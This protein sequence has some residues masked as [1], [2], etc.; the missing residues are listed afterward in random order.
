MADTW[1]GHGAAI[2]GLPDTQKSILSWIDGRSWLIQSRI[3]VAV[4]LFSAKSDRDSDPTPAQPRQKVDP[5]EALGHILAKEGMTWSCC[6]CGQTWTTAAIK[7]VA[8]LGRCPGPKQWEQEPNLNCQTWRKIQGSRLTINGIE[9]H[10][11]HS[12]EWYRGVAYCIKCGHYSS[13]RKLKKLC[14]H[15]QIEGGTFYKVPPEPH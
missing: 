5:L 13:G 3:I 6:L 15:L 8:S 7:R 2:Q 1:A 11:T 14:F 4:Q 9:I 10:R 12:L